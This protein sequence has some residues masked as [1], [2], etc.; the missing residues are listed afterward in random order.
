MHFHIILTERCNSRCRYCYEKSMKEFD[1]GL[2]EKWNFDFDAPF[3]S[4]VNIKNLK[5]FLSQDKT[6]VLIFYGGEPLLQ[7]EKIKKIINEVPNTRFCIQTNGKLLDKIPEEYVNRISKILVSI[8]GDRE[9]TDFN[10]GKGTYEL[11]LKNLRL[12]RKN[13][14]SGEIVVRMTISQIFPDISEQI[15]HLLD[16]KIFDSV[17]W[18]IDAGFYKNDF[19]K[20][21]FRRFAEEYN[22]S[23]SE[24]I[25]YWI[26]EMQNGNVLRLYPFLAI[27]NSM[28]K[29]EPAK[30]R[31]GSGYANYTITTSGK[32]S[33][34]PV[35]NSIR[36]FYC[37]DLNSKISEIKQIYVG[38]PCVSCDYLNLCGGR[39]LYSNKAKLWP[40]E[41]E[42]L[43]CSTVI[44]LIEELKRVFPNI[45]NLISEGK[46]KEKDFEYEKYFGPEIIP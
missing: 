30:L 24:L 12:I 45:K 32:L 6:P 31:C 37:G 25:N 4:E 33:A 42:K 39:C 34:C 21:K 9:R 14:F 17:H 5:Q 15:K 11:V 44:H 36:E 2:Q 10:K 41:G 22:N 38:E 8:D 46:I 43:I 19:D 7:I 23:I 28:L 20:E 3:D 16:T 40:E 29:N 27:V 13:R 1:N 18:Q 35:M 26:K